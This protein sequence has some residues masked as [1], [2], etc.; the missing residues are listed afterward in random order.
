VLRRDWVVG[1]ASPGP[2]GTFRLDIFSHIGYCADRCL[3][4][5]ERAPA[6]QRIAGG[7]RKLFPVQYLAEDMR[8]PGKPP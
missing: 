2:A 5:A 7:Y 8:I 3:K 1:T 6:A 4:T